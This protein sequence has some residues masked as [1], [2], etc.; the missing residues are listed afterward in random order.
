VTKKK[1]YR[2][3]IEK[4][5]PCSLTCLNIIDCSVRRDKSAILLNITALLVRLAQTITKIYRNKILWFVFP[6]KKIIVIL[7]AYTTICS[8]LNLLLIAPSWGASPYSWLKVPF[9]EAGGIIRLNRTGISNI[10]W[11]LIQEIRCSG[12]TLGLWKGV[13]ARSYMYM[14]EKPF[15][16][17][18][19]CRM[20]RVLTLGQSLLV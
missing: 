16:S 4:N 20:D 17:K 5:W 9:L 13:R 11:L 7:L 14:K 19:P 8:T 2:I 3:I 1:V 15:L 12:A 6:R 18:A 10:N